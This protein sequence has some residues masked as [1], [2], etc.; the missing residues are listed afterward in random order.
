MVDTFHLARRMVNR[1]TPLKHVH[2]VRSLVPRAARAHVYDWHPGRARR[3]RRRGGLGERVDPRGH[4]VVTLDDGPDDDATPAVL[5]ALDATLARVMFFVLASQL[6]RHSAIARMRW[7]IMCTRSAC[8]VMTTS[9]MIGLPL[10]AAG[11]T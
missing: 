5:D 6:R 2:K 1:M 9:A 7:S 4:A 10:P 11:R 8:T 3:W